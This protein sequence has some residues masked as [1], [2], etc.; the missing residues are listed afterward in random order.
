MMRVF[1]GYEQYMHAPWQEIQE[2][3]LVWVAELKAKNE[4]AEEERKQIEKASRG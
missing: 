3:T 4:Q 1:G 2:Q